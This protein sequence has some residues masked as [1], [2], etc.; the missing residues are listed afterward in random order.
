MSRP[1]RSFDSRSGGCSG[2]RP[3]HPPCGLISLDSSTTVSRL[4]LLNVLIYARLHGTLLQIRACLTRQSAEPSFRQRVPFLRSPSV[5]L[6]QFRREQDPMGGDP[7]EMRSYMWYCF[8]SSHCAL[9]RHIPRD[10]SPNQITLCGCLCAALAC[11]AIWYEWWGCAF[12][13]HNLY[14][15]FDNLDGMHA[16]ATGQCS[17]YGCM[18][19]HFVDGTLGLSCIWL[20]NR[21]CFLDSF[22]RTPEE[23]LH[24]YMVTFTCGH[25]AGYYSGKIVLGTKL[26][27]NIMFTM[28]D[29]SF[30]VGFLLL[31]QWM[32]FGRLPF[33]LHTVFMMRFVLWPTIFAIVTPAVL[34]SKRAM[35]MH[36]ALPL[37]G[38]L[39]WVFSWPTETLGLVPGIA[40]YICL[41][42]RVLL[43]SS[44]L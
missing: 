9:A 29:F 10:V 39:V 31:W 43:W 30:L 5:V 34:K 18:L 22:E 27:H 20:I 17:R 1:C 28:D 21:S 8:E 15:I 25:M 37:L 40:I 26:A 6:D 13:L 2:A 12:I 23:F 42:G 35:T 16:R 19:D 36:H 11:A 24:L 14:Q 38:W 4:N 44:N 3:A 33:A 41:L 7:K 32:G